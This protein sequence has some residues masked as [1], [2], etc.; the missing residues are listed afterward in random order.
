MKNLFYDFA[1]VGRDGQ[2]LLCF[3]HAGSKS[4]AREGSILLLLLLGPPLAL[5]SVVSKFPGFAG[6]VIDV[7][8]SLLVCRL[9]PPIS[10]LVRAHCAS[11]QDPRTVVQKEQSEA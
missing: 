3:G 10:S 9:A 5:P 1:A 2:L 4:F 8:A 7:A 6:I 11:G